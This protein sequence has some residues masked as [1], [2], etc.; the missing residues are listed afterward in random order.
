[1]DG[2]AGYDTKMTPLSPEPKPRIDPPE[3]QRPDELDTI[4]PGLTDES[5]TLP[6]SPDEVLDL[7]DGAATDVSTE[8]PAG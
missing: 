2:F 5:G 4:S 6:R 8:E 7:P 1:M 3:P